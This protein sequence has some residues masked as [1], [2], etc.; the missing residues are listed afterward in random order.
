MRVVIV[1]DSERMRDRIRT[2]CEDLGGMEVVGE[3]SDAIE[4]TRLIQAEAPEAVILDIRIPLG[5]GFDVMQTIRS[6]S[7]ATRVIELTNFPLEPYREKALSL[8]AAYFFD[9]ST[10]FEQVPEA[11]LSLAGEHSDGTP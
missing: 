6:T 8:G 5:N 9:K 10:E 11:L 7:P 1:E 3:A 4:A 2:V